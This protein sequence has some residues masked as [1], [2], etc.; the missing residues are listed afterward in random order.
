[1]L[2]ETQI[3]TIRNEAL[4]SIM[5]EQGSIRG[6]LGAYLDTFEPSEM[7]EFIS[8]DPDVVLNILGFDPD[9]GESYAKDDDDDACTVGYPESQGD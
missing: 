9:T 3:E 7:T 5:Q 2:T 4:E 6:Y 8:G 1:M